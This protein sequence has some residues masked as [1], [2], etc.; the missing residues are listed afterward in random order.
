MDNNK[1]DHDFKKISS[2]IREL[3]DLLDELF[4]DINKEDRDGN[5]NMVK[6]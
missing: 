2:K 5:T 4:M 3:L 6:K 1:V